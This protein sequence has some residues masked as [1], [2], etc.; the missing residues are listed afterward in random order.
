MNEKCTVLI[1]TSS[2]RSEAGTCGAEGGDVWIGAL[3]Q[4][5]ERIRPCVKR[6]V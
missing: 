3:A 5:R 6:A 4:G 2:A 1:C